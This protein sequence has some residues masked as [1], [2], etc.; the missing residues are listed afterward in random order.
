MI[1]P[2]ALNR[3]IDMT[4]L[5]QGFPDLSVG[6]RLGSAGHDARILKEGIC[7]QHGEQLECLLEVIDHLLRRHVVCVAGRV[8]GADASA[9]LAPFVFPER[10]VVAPVILPIYGHVVQQVVPVEV[11]QDLGDVLV[12]SGF[13]AELLVGSIAFIGPKR[14]RVLAFKKQAVVRCEGTTDH[15][16]WTVQWSAGPVAGLV[17]QNC[18]C[19]KR[20]PG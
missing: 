10:F 7:V 17:S 18:V 3:S 8:K 16:P 12:L 19:S 11:F 14:R 9:V 20:P 15:K 4:V 13:I 6:V 5:D 2:T 1:S